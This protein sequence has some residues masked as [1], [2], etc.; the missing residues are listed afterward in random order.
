MHRLTCKQALDARLIHA[1]ISAMSSRLQHPER[2][3]STTGLNRTPTPVVLLIVIQRM[4]ENLQNNPADK[5]ECVL[6]LAEADANLDIC[7]AVVP[8]ATR[9]NDRAAVSTSA[10]FQMPS[11]PR[12]PPHLAWAAP[13]QSKVAWELLPWPALGRP[14]G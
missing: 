3:H 4:F 5:I 7:R 13:T 8:L 14:R 12:T 11:T 9:P 10:G 1:S 2:N 6:H